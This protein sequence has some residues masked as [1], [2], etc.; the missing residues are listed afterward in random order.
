MPENS[1]FSWIFGYNTKF[2]SG[3][4]EFEF[5]N[6]GISVSE[7]GLTEFE[8][9]NSVSGSGW[10]GFDLFILLSYLTRANEEFLSWQGWIGG[11]CYC[12]LMSYLFPTQLQLRWL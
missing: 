7:F 11:Y 6:S 10:E 5:Q 4:T 2:C 1:G 12:S 3:S 8:F 9:Q